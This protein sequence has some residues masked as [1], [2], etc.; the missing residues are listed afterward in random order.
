MKHTLLAAVALAVAAAQPAAAPAASYPIP[1]GWPMST[2][3]GNK[4]ASK[5]NAERAALLL[6]KLHPSETQPVP[7]EHFFFGANIGDWEAGQLVG[8]ASAMPSAI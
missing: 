2:R 4:S 8:D 3:S 5:R 1:N 7:P 6:H